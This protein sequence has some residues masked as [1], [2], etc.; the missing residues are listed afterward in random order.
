MLGAPDMC[1]EV[2]IWPYMVDYGTEQMVD[3]GT[4]MCQEVDIWP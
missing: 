3:Y 2:D 4:D 1:Q